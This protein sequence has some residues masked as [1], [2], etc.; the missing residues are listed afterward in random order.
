MERVMVCKVWHGQAALIRWPALVV[1][2]QM[3]RAPGLAGAKPDRTPDHTVVCHTYRVC[4]ATSSEISASTS[5][6]VSPF[7]LGLVGCCCP[8][9]SL[10]TFPTQAH[11]ITA[12]PGPVASTSAS[13]AVRQT[14]HLSWPRVCRPHINLTN[15]SA[16]HGSWEPAP[17]FAAQ[18]SAIKPASGTQGGPQSAA[19]SIVRFVQ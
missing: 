3:K 4:P 5:L 11:P 14:L 2:T 9:K 15:G 8:F 17:R 12:H 7:W 18:P 19:A 16:L 6:N 13:C 1:Q 10:L